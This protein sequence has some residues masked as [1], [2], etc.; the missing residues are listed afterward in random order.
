M[1]PPSMPRLRPRRY[2]SV[3]ARHSGPRGK[4]RRHARSRVTQPVRY[5]RSGMSPPQRLD[6]SPRRDARPFGNLRWPIGASLRGSSPAAFL[7]PACSRW[8]PTANTNRLMQ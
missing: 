5:R 1:G 3:V 4:D 8:R 6:A 2:R 7:P